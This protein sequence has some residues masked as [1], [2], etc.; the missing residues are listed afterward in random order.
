[1]AKNK[2]M[3]N[4]KIYEI[5]QKDK[6]VRKAIVKRS[7][8]FFFFYYFAHYAEFPIAPFHE[9]LF[10][11]TQANTSSMLVVSAFRGSGKSTLLT[12]SYV[13]WSIIN[14]STKYTLIV[15]ENQQKAVT[16][17]SHIKNELENNEM[18][19]KDLGP[20][21]EERLTWN[22]V[23]LHIERYNAKITAVSSEQSVR[24]L[25]HFNYRPGLIVVDDV[26]S[27]ESVRTLESRDKL[28]RWF[29]GDMIPAGNQST[30][31][32]VIGSVLHP[33]CL[34]KRLQKGIDDG[35]INGVYRMYPIV[36]ADGNPTWLGKYP[37]ITAVEQE[38]LRGV[39][40][41]E[42]TIEYMLQPILDENQVIKPEW[43]QYYDR[44]PNEN[45]TDF[46]YSVSGV[47]LA[48]SQTES[49]DYTAIVSGTVY[50]KDDEK[51]KLYIFP[52]PI[53]E[54]L[55]GPA[56]Q[57]KIVAQSLLLGE[58]HPTSVYIEDV[59]FQRSIIDF[60]KQKGIP[61][62]GVSVAGNDKRARLISISELVKSGR[63]LFPKNGCEK[64][65]QQLVYFGMEKHDDLSDALTILVLKFFERED[66]SN[67]TFPRNNLQLESP[68]PQAELEKE[69]DALAVLK[70]DAIRSGDKTMWRK[71]Y[72]AYNKKLQEESRARLREEELDVFQKLMRRRRFGY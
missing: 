55:N 65:I 63:V 40:D 69:A 61:A 53:N 48:I 33:D 17:L 36:D 27:Q 50:Q 59:A 34:V 13:I 58:G 21:R 30:K 14:G 51:S 24:G 41:R 32:I 43:I 20:F 22:A 57:D 35:K 5:M 52:F 8:K 67:F 66:H 72:D 46:K 23:S 29:T 31:V 2:H 28:Y 1:M 11:L 6:A 4:E 71:Y 70:Q 15:S 47:D 64:L 39:T 10:Q 56:I 60:I 62:E 44:I 25:R 49:A 7:H 54:R 45:F 37:D 18:L 9:E 26:E 19:R 3:T 38:K 42:W 16:F 12:L 68:K